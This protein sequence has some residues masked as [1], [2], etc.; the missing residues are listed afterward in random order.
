MAIRLLRFGSNIHLK[1]S[2]DKLAV[3]LQ[4]KL[5]DQMKL[6]ERQGLKEREERER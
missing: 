5:K 2:K 4:N 1:D 6:M 3:I